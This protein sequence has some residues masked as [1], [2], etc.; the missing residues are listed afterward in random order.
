M[1][2]YLRRI[3]FLILVILFFNVSDAAIVINEFM[4]SN[5]SE[6]TDPD[7]NETADWIEIYNS[8]TQA[9]LLKG[10]FIT[11]NFSDPYK[12]E[13][14]DNVEIGADKYL[15]I[16]ADGKNEGLHTNFKISAD[17]EELAIVS[18]SGVFLDSIKFGAQSPNI[19][20]GRTSNLNDKKVYFTNP[21][22]GEKNSSIYFFDIVRSI[23]SFS[24]MG[25]IFKSSFGLSLETKF[26]GEVKYTIDGSEP[27]NNSPS[28]TKPIQISKN[29]VVRARIIKPEMI[30]GPVVSNTYLF[31][32]DEEIN[33]LPV[34]SITASPKDLWDEETGIYVQDY[35][36]E[37]EIP[38]NIEMFENDGS[39]RAAFNL[40]AGMKINGLYSWQLPQ[41]MLG[42]YFR[43]KYGEGKLDYPLIFDKSRKSFK[44]F[45]LRASGS[46]WS[47]SM[48]RDAMV[49]NSTMENT[50]L[51]NSGFRAC[52]VYFNGQY[53]GIHNIREKIDEDFIIGNHKV[54]GGSID[55]VENENYAEAGNLDSYNKFKDLYLKDLTVKA[56]WDSVLN[57]MNII[58]F[59]DLICTE[60]YDGNTSISHNI[61]A[62][63][64]KEGGLWKWIIMDLDRGFF[65]VGQHLINYYVNQDEWPFY[66][67]I[68]NDYY[69]HYFGKR[70][71]DHL[72]TTFNPERINKLIDL[73]KTTIEKEM[74]NH[75][76]RWEGTSSSYG[77]PIPSMDYWYDEIESMKFFAENRPVVLLD[78]LT[79]YGFNE[80]LP[81]TVSTAPSN[82]GKLTLNGLKVPVAECKGGY[83]SGEEITMVAEANNGYVFKGWSKAENIYL[84]KSEDNWKYNDSG[85]YPGD[86]WMNSDYDDS[87]WKTGKAELGYGEN[88]ENTVIEYGGDTRNKYPAAYFRKNFIYKKDS[89]IKDLKAAVKYDDGVIIYLNGKEISRINMPDGLIDNET[90][91]LS[92]V[93]SEEENIFHEIIIDESLLN[94]GENTL[95][96]EV[97]QVNA[98]SSDLS[99]D[100][101]MMGNYQGGDEYVSNT[102]SY[103]FIFNEGMSL[104]AVFEAEGYCE[105]PSEIKNTVT[106]SKDCSPYITTGDV[107]IFKGGKL[108]INPG[109]EI[110]VQ[111]GASFYISGNLNAKGTKSDPV[112]FKSNPV[113]SNDK[114]G[115]ISFTNAVD[116][117]FFN[118]VIIQ[119]ASFGK[120]PVREIAAISAFNSVI[121]IDSI[122]ITDVEANPISGRYSDITLT[123]SNLHS[124]IT[125]DCIN[126][127]YG[128]GKVDNCEFEGNDQPDSDA[129]DYD[130]VK[131]GIIVNSRIHDFSGFNSDGIDIGEKAENIKIENVLIHD[132]TDK[133]IS[134]GQESSVKVYNTV[135]LKSNLGVGIKDSSN[136]LI[137]HCTFYGNNISV[138]AFEK[139][140]GHAG[141][142]VQIFNSILSNSY[143]SSFSKDVF[144]TM[145]I[146]YSNS[147]NDSLTIGEKNLFSDPSFL[148]PTEY[149]FSLLSNSSC[150]N[151]GSDGNIGASLKTD[152]LKPDIIICDIAYLTDPDKEN[153]EF[154]GIYNP[155]EEALNISG[156]H[157][158][159]GVTFTFPDDVVIFPKEKVYVTSNTASSFW[160][161]RGANFYLWES[162]KLA[163]EGEKI[164]LVTKSGIVIDQVKYNNKQ[165]WPIVPD[166]YNA[167]TLKTFSV[168][169]HFGKNWTSVT[170]DKIVK[171]GRVEAKNSIKVYP[172]PSDGFVTI[173]GL[174]KHDQHIELFDLTGK[175]IK[176]EPI[177]N[178]TTLLNLNGL[179]SGFYL[180]K[181]GNQTQKLIVR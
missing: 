118:N 12:W 179:F 35:K 93:G 50:D 7:F 78:N 165:P 9:V 95:A 1:K 82:G 24:I 39:D 43:K 163:D 171:T 147:D 104:S 161:G 145:S 172:N 151:N 89:N 102:E 16:W 14:K 128:K 160:E 33:D 134:V 156:Y 18:P 75:I 181:V 73:H 110:F 91:A 76:K 53:M 71:A 22:P 85:N 146:K 109:V 44:T 120:H 5:S 69:K 96:V 52:V 64:P 103:T 176:K 116:T 173:K 21:T 169:N 61:M 119:N 115:V 26:Q 67:L 180:L 48:F 40:R 31:D 152:L 139:I 27:T 60:V 135:I 106:L 34:I 174:N 36:P 159:E 55:M 42:I 138:S 162:G 127:K 65:N 23:P 122:T 79:D 68:E 8:G 112:T 142:N 140:P 6:E 178:E 80:P 121:V 143:E 51:D 117:S 25:G 144:S 63:K 158:E 66:K 170:K 168:D 74:P 90:F 126:V 157:F 108:I 94:E 49:Q 131:D 137:N 154:I 56:N 84:I 113:N 97:H 30:P 98:S 132:I 153:L 124:K 17:G 177:L 59:T 3:F 29:T 141:G 111:K 47:N 2:N 107:N 105:I 123:N 58:N 38:I 150:I 166:S 148:N 130:D 70:L 101:Y 37:W 46:D 57:F 77:D 100:F 13:I 15:V 155:G 10:Y 54:E 87:T 86:N 28:F 133:G 129:I 19:S 88:D 41:K 125:G 83:P 99:F 4:A 175:L 11:D 45:A 149:D 62:W 32:T 164:R 136:T 114:W 81:L 92:S 72:F 167:I 20:V